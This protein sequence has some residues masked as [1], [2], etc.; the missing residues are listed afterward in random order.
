MRVG[1]V[2]RFGIN[3][4]RPIGHERQHHHD[5]DLHRQALRLRRHL[6]QPVD[7]CRQSAHCPGADAAVRTDALP[8][9]FHPDHLGSTSV[10]TNA[11]GVAEEHNSYRP[12][13]Q[14]H[15]HT[16]TSDVAYKYTGQERDPSTGLYFYNARYYDPALGRFISPDTIVESPLHPQT[17]NRY[18]YAGNNPVLYNDPTGHCFLVCIII[19]AVVGAVSAGIASD[20]DLGATLLG[21]AIGAFSGGVGGKVG[22]FVGTAVKSQYGAVAGGAAGGLAGGAAAGGTSALLY[23]AAGYNVNVGLAIGAGAAAGLV[24]GAVGFGG[25]EWG[26]DKYAAVFAGAAS[27]GAV[28]STIMGNDPGIGALYAVAAAGIL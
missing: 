5:H 8:S 2:I 21:G 25:Y 11:Q 27:G 12:Y 15:T 9:Y 22:G 16:G 23:R 20:W 10:L 13:G 18:A 4:S 7:L 6:M 19:G 28:S 14:L 3:G 24:G 17:L 1:S 26:L